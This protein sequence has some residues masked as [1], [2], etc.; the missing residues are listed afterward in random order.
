VTECVLGHYTDTHS[1]TYIGRRVARST[2]DDDG[3][4][5]DIHSIR[6]GHVGDVDRRESTG[7]YQSI[8]VD[9]VNTLSGDVIDQLSTGVDIEDVRR[10]R[11]YERL[12]PSGIAALRQTPTPHHYSALAAAAESTE[13]ADAEMMEIS[14]FNAD[15]VRQQLCISFLRLCS[16]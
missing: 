11:S 9:R 5:S 10:G 12:D 3:H 8:D 6:A 13:Q 4:H 1:T 16:A 15:T 14:Q 7:H 2:D